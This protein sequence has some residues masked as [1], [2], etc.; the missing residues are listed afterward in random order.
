MRLLALG[1]ALS[2]AACADGVPGST[3]PDEHPTLFLDSRG[4]R[5]GDPAVGP[6]ELIAFGTGRGGVV[7]ALGSTGRPVSDGG[8]DASCGAGPL[9]SATLAD[10][11]TLWF[12][13]EALVGW[14]TQRAGDAPPAYAAT[15]GLGVGSTRAA[16]DGAYRVDVQETTLGTEFYTGVPGIPGGFGGL[17]DGT[18]PEAIVTA[19]WAGTTCT[20]R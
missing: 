15:T 20:V 19:L 7:E 5:L 9:D 16:L 17:L 12:D 8:T 18:G 11:L 4:L 3:P 14:S 10:D 6:S 13:D 2:L 1:L